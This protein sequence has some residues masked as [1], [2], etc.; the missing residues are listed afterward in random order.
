MTTGALMT[1]GATEQEKRE[2]CIRDILT[3]WHTTCGNG[4]IS[5]EEAENIL[6]R[7]FDILLERM[8]PQHRTSMWFGLDGEE[9]EELSSEEA[10]QEI[11]AFAGRLRQLFTYLFNVRLTTAHPS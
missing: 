6:R 8:T 5:L 11:C 10:G 1:D 2:A 3:R 7:D 4:P 9:I